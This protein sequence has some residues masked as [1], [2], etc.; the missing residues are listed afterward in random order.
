MDRYNTV[1]KDYVSFFLTFASRNIEKVPPQ[2]K[3]NVTLLSAEQKPLYSK[4]SNESSRIYCWESVGSGW[5][6]PRFTRKG[7]LFQLIKDDPL[8]ICCDLI[9]PLNGMYTSSRLTLETRQLLPLPKLSHDFKSMLDG[10]KFG[11]TTIEA[12]NGKTFSVCRAILQARSSV[13][14]VM[15]EH[16]MEEQQQKRIVIDDVEPEVLREML[17]YIYTGRSHK[18]FG[19]ARD[20]LYMADK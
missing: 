13:F 14:A 17:T 12:S 9:I 3:F 7:A 2:V 10:Q 1:S 16:D 6:F 4:N 20:L 5:G 18:L 15:F 19:M 8:I 11:D